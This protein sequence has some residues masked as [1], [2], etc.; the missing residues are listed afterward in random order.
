MACGCY[1][2]LWNGGLGKN[3]IKNRSKILEL[4]VKKKKKKFRELEKA[5]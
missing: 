4:S 2:V 1:Q 3:K 5:L